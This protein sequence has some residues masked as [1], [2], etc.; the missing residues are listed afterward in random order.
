MIVQKKCKQRRPAERRAHHEAKL[1]RSGH[2]GPVRQDVHLSAAL[3]L[4]ADLCSI[5]FVAARAAPRELDAELLR[6]EV[7]EVTNA[8]LLAG[9]D[10]VVLGLRLLQD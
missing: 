8:V 10:D 1:V 2:F 6:G 7:D 9:G 3:P 4:G 5:P